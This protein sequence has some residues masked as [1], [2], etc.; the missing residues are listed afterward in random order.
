MAKDPPSLDISK[1]EP[2]AGLIEI[3]DKFPP[4]APNAPPIEV[5]LEFPMSL[6]KL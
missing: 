5:N 3:D 4:K 6:L 1:T 2:D